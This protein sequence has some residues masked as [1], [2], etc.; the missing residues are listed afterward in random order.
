MRKRL[1][2]LAFSLPLLL[3]LP[4]HAEPG[5]PDEA[6]VAGALDEHPAVLAARSRLQAARAEARAL[7]RGPHELTL[8]GSYVRRT[9][10]REG[11]FD[12]YDAQITRAFRLPGKAGLDREIGTYG[13]DA[14][15]NR[16]EDAKHQTALM[17][18]QGWWDWLAAAGE[19]TIDRK[20]VANYEKLLAA[21]RRRVA[22][23]DAA[24]LD[25]DQTEAALGAAR[26]AAEQSAGRERLTRERLATQFPSLPLPQTAPD[27]P[28]PSLPEAG[29]ETY[30]QRVIDNSHEIAAADAEWRKMESVATR[31]RRD[32]F[33]DPSIGARFFSERS[34]AERGVGVLLSIPLGGG[35]RSA[36][37]DR[38][39]AEATAAGAEAQVARFTVRET[40]NTDV[41]E[42]QYRF[43]AWRRAREG[44]DAQLA[45]LMKLRR[46]HET[47]EIDLSDM[48]YGERQVHDAFR[49]EA[50]A[51]AEAQ[52]AITKLRIDSHELWL[53]D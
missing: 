9:V 20:A 10:D 14:A 17:L 2:L 27:V 35:H 45:A 26:L 6:A 37:A 12:E 23:R 38:A 34:G 47:G 44:L 41:T 51:R 7:A 24:Q 30:R 25:A 21:T 3:A 42:A 8:S 48:L 4:A 15:E 16:A 13:I 52:R 11:K 33:A 29:L 49:V 18:A 36:L 1:A 43:E 19:A 50:Q 31:T 46:G 53:G 39:S 28:S 5:L 22:M 32:R 40:A